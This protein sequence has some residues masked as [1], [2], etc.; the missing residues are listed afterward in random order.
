MCDN[1]KLQRCAF[2]TNQTDARQEN[3][4]LQCDG[5]EKD[6]TSEFVASVKKCQFDRWSASSQYLAD[7]ELF[8]TVF[9]HGQEHPMEHTEKTTSTSMERSS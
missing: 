3:D 8:Y 7:T 9:W 5:S 1:E 4:I 2:Y 6:L